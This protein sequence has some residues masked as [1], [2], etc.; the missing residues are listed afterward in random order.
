M[1]DDKPQEKDGDVNMAE[2]GN[3]NVVPELS[4]T[5]SIFEDQDVITV[6]FK[7]RIKEIMKY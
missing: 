3:V 6:N 1:I 7:G 4:K 2:E 5:N